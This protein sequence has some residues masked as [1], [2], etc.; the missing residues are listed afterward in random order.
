[1]TI[2]SKFEYGQR[3]FWLEHNRVTSAIVKS[4]SFGRFYRLDG[5]D[6][7]ETITYFVSK[8]KKSS[9]IN[10]QGGGLKESQ[11]FPSKKELL[12]SL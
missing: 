8:N 3:I 7:F 9:I 2:T 6:Y 1:M 12:K 11:C 5:K 10:Y 4:I